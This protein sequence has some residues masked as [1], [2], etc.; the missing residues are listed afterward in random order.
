MTSDPK[1]SS[2]TPSFSP[3]RRWKIGFDLFIRTLV[4]LAVIIMANYLGSLFS[5]QFFMSPQTQVHL[6]P[7]TASILESLT[8]HVDVTVYYDKNDR[9]YSMVMALLNEYHRLDHRITVKVVDYV[10]EPGEAAVITQKYRLP[11]QASNPNGPPAKNLVIFDCDGHVKAVPG[12][13]LVEYG[14]N[15][16]VKDKKIEF[17]PVAFKGEMMF[18]ATL[19]AV[20]N[21]KPFIAY[22]LIGR[23][24]PSPAD[25]GDGGYLK[26]GAILG[27]NYIRL[28]PLTLLAGSDIPADCNLLIIAGPTERFSDSELTKIDH[29]I[30]Q[31][32][33]LLV[34]LDYFSLGQPTGMEDELA[35]W[36]V[37]V[38]GD[39]VQDRTDTISGKDVIVEHFSTHPVVNPLMD[40]ALELILPRPVGPKNDPNAPPDAPTVTTLAVSSPNSVLTDERGGEPH[41]YPLMVAV[42][43]NSPS[44]GVVSPGANLRMVVVGDSMFLN[45]QYIEAGANR[46]FA[47]YAVNW[48]LDRP[49]LLKGIGP[50]P[51]VEYRLMMNKKQLW[52]VRWLVLGA[53]P[54]TALVVGGLVWLRRRK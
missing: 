28:A 9:M 26:F 51:V 44:K 13:A 12:D 40:S 41:S 24:E 43:G 15:G 47:G 54:C 21:P 33:R 18:T 6:S 11:S 2:P 17:A 31:G 50:R 14:P 5:W 10:R 48:L 8:N 4:V 34:L 38:G 36:G 7:R 42:Q 23:G 25:T 49:M 1:T 27:E 37:N 20:T 30:A 22:Y 16:V 3:A 52:N 45:N 32:G 19:L 53:L 35:R 29:Y 46:D 39:V